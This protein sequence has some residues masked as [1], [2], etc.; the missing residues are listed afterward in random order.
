MFSNSYF[1]ISFL[2]LK[3]EEGAVDYIARIV[4][5]F[6]SVDGEPYFKARWF[7]RAEDTVRLFYNYLII[8]SHIVLLDRTCNLWF[9]FRSLRILHVLLTEKEYFFQM[10][11]MTTHWIALYL[12]L[13]SL[14]WQPM[15]HHHMLVSFVFS[16]FLL[17][18]S[19]FHIDINDHN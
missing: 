17:L 2:C 19:C 3:A 18:S 10:S 16:P 15:Y 11:K 6:E 1:Y 13:K 9:N 12:K 5:L 4:E 7:Y 14:K 8:S